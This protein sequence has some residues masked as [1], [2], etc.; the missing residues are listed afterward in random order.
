M[1]ISYGKTTPHTPR[2]AS[3]QTVMASPQALSRNTPK[4]PASDRWSRRVRRLWIWSWTVFA[5]VCLTFTLVNLNLFGLFGSSPTLE[6]LQGPQLALPSEVYSADSVLLGKYFR[7]N[8]TPVETNEISP[9]LF[10]ALLATEDIR[11]EDHSGIDPAATLAIFYSLAKGDNRG[12]STIT[13][14][15]AKNLFKTRR[16]NASKGL[17]SKIPGAGTLIAKI[18][19]WNTAVKLEKSYT[20]E[21]IITYYF[22]TVDFGRNSYGINAAA[23]TFFSKKPAQIT[24][25]EAALLV[26]MLKA[27]SSYNP[28]RNPARALARRNTVL[29]QMA[30]YDFISPEQL[31]SLTAIPIAL[32]E[33][34]EEHSDGPL[35]Y[36]NQALTGWLEQWAAKNERD[37]YGEG[38]KIYLTVDTRYQKYAQEAMWEH[39]SNLQQRF[40][41]HWRGQH[42]WRDESGKEI[43]GFLDYHIQRTDHW[44]IAMRRY[45][46]NMDSVT[47]YL[48]RP[49][50]MTIFK[51]EQ[52]EPAY[53]E[54]EMS[55]MDSLAYYKS[56]LHAGFMVLNPFNGHVKAWVGGL[57]FNHFKYDHV[58][59]SKRQPGSTFKGFVYAAAIENGKGPCDRLQDKYFQVQ[60]EEED[61]GLTV[62]RE[63]SPSNATGYFS[64]INMT[65]R[66]GMGRS[67]NSIAAQLTEYLG[68]RLNP[69][70]KE[71]LR[72][73]LEKEGFRGS[74]PDILYGAT[75]VAD[76]A[77]KLGIKS[78]LKPVPSIGLGSNDVSLYEMLSAYSTF[79][80]QGFTGEPILVTRIEDKNEKELQRFTAMHHRVISP[81]TAWLMVHM[82]KGTLQEPQ[83][84]AQ[85]LFSFDLFRGNE[86]AGKTGTSQNQSDGWFIGL[87]KDLIGGAWAGAEERSVHF[88]TLRAG[89][90]SKTALPM[91]GL[92]MEKVYRDRSLGIRM[93]YFPKPQVKI[94]KSYYCTTY[95]PKPKIETDST[96]I[97]DG[98]SPTDTLQTL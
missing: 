18:K 84:T 74:L 70:E 24:L 56:L 53:E 37:L 30:K 9:Y 45:K 54:K 51:W 58:R 65:L 13:Q 12:G 97:P 92:F 88:R 49:K 91:Y 67:I 81:E 6:G 60:Y 20:K 52:G 46:G 47:A 62:K 66:Y 57:D 21:E 61:K 78:P 77:H 41:G 16:G 25:E 23:K 34:K 64:G 55:P 36:Y 4:A 2:R 43:E 69:E 76:F 79:Q 32:K 85:A 96:G 68:E 35:D 39:M 27:T 50:K 1:T 82:L 86:M 31:D 93:G 75:V 83:G 48:N 98:I 80:N 94:R 72:P 63:W 38:L 28:F 5:A 40:R 73:R 87:S 89:E 8:R 11:F 26:G 90:G 19:E 7:E 10:Q 17:L 42:P 33:S 59:Q 3:L 22:N 95:V 71:A 15:L 29:G 44:K 14:Q